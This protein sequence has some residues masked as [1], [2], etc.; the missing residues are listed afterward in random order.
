MTGGLV[1]N[2]DSTVSNVPGS[3][4]RLL[5][6]LLVCGLFPVVVVAQQDAGGRGP[7]RRAASVESERPVSPEQESVALE[8]ARQH[9]R[10][11]AGLLQQLKR[12]N[13]QRYE[14]AVV[15]L[16]RTSERLSRLQERSPERYESELEIWKLDSR[17]RL[18]AARASSGETDAIRQEIKQLLLKR[19]RVR[20]AQLEADRERLQTRL[21]RMSETIKRLRNESEET[22]ERE[23]ERLLRAAR[24]R[25]P[26]RA[27]K[28]EP[29]KSQP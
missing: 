18:L 15:E 14:N 22:A 10:E 9:H 17:I 2:S 20:A 28:T 25:R 12:S 13:P 1:R 16:Y 29:V 6:A 3:R 5:M 7:Q 24:T 26:P 27:D 8:F 19:N 21:E 23:L 4:A 11:L